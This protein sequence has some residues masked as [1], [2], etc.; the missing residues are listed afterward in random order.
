M[1]SIERLSSESDYSFLEAEHLHRYAMACS[2]SKGKTVMDVACGEGYGSN[3]LAKHAKSVIGIDLD[4]SVLE[5]AQNKYRNINRNLTF[6]EGS[7][8][9]LPVGDN[10]M[11]MVVSFESIEHVENHDQVFSEFKRVLKEDGLL[12]LSTPDKRYYTDLGGQ[13]NPFHLKEMY[14]ADLEKYLLKY[15]IN[16][17]VFQQRFYQGSLIRPY[18]EKSR[19]LT[20]YSGDFTQVGMKS[21]DDGLYMIAMAS[22]TPVVYGESSFFDLTD[23]IQKTADRRIDSIFNSSSYKIGRAIVNVCRIFWRKS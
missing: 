12:I 16:H 3:L 21:I 7:L 17:K 5:G 2:L 23:L 14:R 9:S 8:L 1:H 11:D 6:L 18:E 22:D 19:E 10:S 4:K 15:F 20:I 13:V